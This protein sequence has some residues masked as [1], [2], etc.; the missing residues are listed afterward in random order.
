MTWYN[1]YIGSLE[2]PD[3]QWEGGDP[4]GNIPHPLTPEFPDPWKDFFEV[5][6]RIEAGIYEGKRVDFDGWVAKLDKQQIQDF[7]DD[8]CAAAP[9][10]SS[11]ERTAE[12]RK[13]IDALD[14][15]KLYA[16][17]AAAT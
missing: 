6:R 9:G 2:D 7:L 11:S 10:R 14:P 8:R 3:F 17:V 4:S 15:N 13:A 5:V 16:L 12:L 1:V